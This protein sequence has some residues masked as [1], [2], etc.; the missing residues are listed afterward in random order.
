MGENFK[1][2]WN[3]HHS[4]FFRTA[5][6]LCRD[7]HLTDITLSCGK[8]EFSAH[9]LV[10][11]VCSSYFKD[12]FT[13]KESAKN[14]PAN[15]AAI[16]YM[17]DVKPDHMELLLN[18][19]Y[20]GEI[21]IDENELMD[22]LATAKGLQ[23]R[24]LCEEEDEEETQAPIETP[25]EK[26]TQVANVA[27]ASSSMTKPATDLNK[28]K[29]VKRPRIVKTKPPNVVNEPEPQNEAEEEE[30]QRGEPSKNTKRIKTE[31]DIIA[32]QSVEFDDSN[33]IEPGDGT[34]PQYDEASGP[35]DEMMYQPEMAQPE[36]RHFFEFTI[37]GFFS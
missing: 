24:G 31:Y 10:L 12:L 23:I 37:V 35:P 15:S 17:K 8:K 16:V 19:M 36:V 29:A 1:L 11:S 25:V 26:S 5:E 30:E 3:D 6:S 14:R 2:R 32:T 7:D 20:R 13:P 21:N 9:K 28:P 22:L 18:F 4:I 27:A 34:D 33:I